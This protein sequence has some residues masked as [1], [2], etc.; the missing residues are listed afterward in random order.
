M[1]IAEWK[2]GW[3]GTDARIG[4]AVEA[5]THG[6]YGRVTVRAVGVPEAGANGGEEAHLVVPNEVIR[7]MCVGG[8]WMT[9]LAEADKRLGNG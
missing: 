9:V 4:I 5:S 8:Q 1:Q 7:A 6:D 2:F 3:R